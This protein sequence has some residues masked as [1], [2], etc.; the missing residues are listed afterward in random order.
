MTDQDT[1]LAML[2][3]IDHKLNT[4]VNEIATLRDAAKGIDDRMLM[5]AGRI[6]DLARAKK[7]ASEGEGGL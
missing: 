1:T 2:A 3:R 5:L 7:R 6:R 4:L